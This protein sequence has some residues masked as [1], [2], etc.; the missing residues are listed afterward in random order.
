MDEKREVIYHNAHGLTPRNP[1]TS[2]ISMVKDM[3]EYS[4]WYDDSKQSKNHT[5]RHWNKEDRSIH[6]WVIDH[7]NKK[8]GTMEKSLSPDHNNENVVIEQRMGTHNNM[9][10]YIS[11]EQFNKLQQKDE[12]QFQWEYNAYINDQPENPMS[13]KTF[14][15]FDPANS[16]SGPK[17]HKN[18]RHTAPW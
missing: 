5:N 11:L 9:N 15:P 14:E 17:P 2:T 7:T 13:N 16:G 3:D 4:T 18:I 8:F 6:K 1:K 10:D 12:R